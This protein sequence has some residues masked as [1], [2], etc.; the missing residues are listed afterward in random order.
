[1][2]VM[3]L[4]Y[5]LCLFFCVCSPR[6]QVKT[7]SANHAQTIMRRLA[8][9]MVVLMIFLMF[10]TWDGIPAMQGV[11]ST[12]R[13][14][15]ARLFAFGIILICLITLFAGGAMLAFGQQMKEFHTFAD[16]FVTTLIVMATGTEE[17][18]EAQFAI[19]PMLASLWHWLLVC[20]MYVV[21]LNLVLCILVDAYGE[22]QAQRDEMDKDM[23]MPTLYEQCV[24]TALYCVESTQEFVFEI[25]KHPAK[26]RKKLSRSTSVAPKQAAASTAAQ[27]ILM[28]HKSRR[29]EAF[30]GAEEETDAAAESSEASCTP[31]E[32]FDVESIVESTDA[33]L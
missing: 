12:I 20:I 21:C 7:L 31:V 25:K 23:H 15:S 33:A 6:E 13:N 18:Y 32:S 17:I 3:L 10:K 27:S 14:A 4:V 29:F 30:A 2:L 26:L 5:L 24:D 16:S 8:F 28:K 11:S 19:D 22:S 1:M 9:F